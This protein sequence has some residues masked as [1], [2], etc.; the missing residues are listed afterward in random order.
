[1]SRIKNYQEFLNEDN[2]KLWGLA[3]G[4]MQQMFSGNLSDPKKEPASVGQSDSKVANPEALKL[5]TASTLGKS[6]DDFL[7]YMQHQQGIA[8]SKQLI[9]AAKGLDKLHPETVKTKAGVKYANLMMNVPSDRPQVKTAITKALDAG[10][11]QEG[12][13]LFL[14]MWKEKWLSKGQEGMKAIEQPKNKAVKEA[15]LKNCLEYGV[16]FDFAVAVANIESGFNPKV[17]NNKYKGLYA[18]TQENFNKIVPGGDI[19]NAEQNAKAGIAGL[20]EA[21]K[22]FKKSLGSD[23][24][25]LNFSPWVKDLA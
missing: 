9:R 18:I 2:Q 10:D 8:G 5:T 6:N 24:A 4:L 1:M 3:R 14:E 20:K 13:K 22:Q 25:G 19:H 21:I 16:P 11:H 7:L 15:I 17:G 23:L 12:A